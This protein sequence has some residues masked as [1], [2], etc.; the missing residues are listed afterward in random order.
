M[1]RTLL[2]ILL[3]IV[4][5]AGLLALSLN[6]KP[7]PKPA[8][9][10]SIAQTTLV[11]SSPVAST[12]GLLKSDI[13]INSRGNRITA[14]QIELSYNPSDI[15]NVDIKIGPFIKNPVELFKKI[16]TQNGR[17]SY[18][19]GVALGEKGV[20]GNGVVAKLSF[21]KLKTI[22]TTSISFL[23]KSLVTSSGISQSVLKSATGLTLDLSK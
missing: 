22:G 11:M 13:T 16:D 9:P 17:V 8:I 10:V 14:I 7:A 15:S 1:N 23:P 2:L 3:L 5:A 4:S 12:S 20:L 21:S 6:T 18:A 19:I